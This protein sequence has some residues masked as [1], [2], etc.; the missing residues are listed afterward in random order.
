MAINAFFGVISVKKTSWKKKRQIKIVN[1]LDYEGA[2]C[3]VS[4]NDYN[5]I[6]QKNNTYINVYS[7]ENNFVYPVYFSDKKFKDCIDLFLK[8]DENK[9]TY[10]YIKD[11]NRFIGKYIFT[12]IV[13]IVLV[14]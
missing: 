7:Y 10:F 4:K 2:K 6:E 14:E 11:F 12:S 1:D 9:S 5:K 8:T 13:Y 3:P